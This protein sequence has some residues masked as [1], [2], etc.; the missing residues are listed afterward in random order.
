VA[1][2][3]VLDTH[4]ILWYLAGS[5]QLGAAAKAILQDQ[6]SE[7]LIPAIALAEACWI[8]EHGKVSLS[9]N[10]LMLAIDS[11]PRIRILPL[12]KI[13]IDRCIGLTAITEMHDRQIVAT[14]LILQDQREDVDLLT[15][16]GNITASNLVTVVW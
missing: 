2:K 10:D 11:D 5:P 16:D 8:V 3:H 6:G 1:A 12:D 15:K 14:T 9:T 4:A 7:L 13:A